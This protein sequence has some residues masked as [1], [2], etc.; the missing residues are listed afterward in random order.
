[1]LWRLNTGVP[2]HDLPECYGKWQT[3]L[4]RFNALRKAGQGGVPPPA[5]QPVVHLLSVAVAL[6]QLAPPGA[7]VQHRGDAAEGRPVLVPLAA[8]PA[9]G[10]QQ[11]RGQGEVPVAQ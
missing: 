9:V 6:G 7:G 5:G 2:W 8:P 3:G 10:R 4:H 11:V 1:V